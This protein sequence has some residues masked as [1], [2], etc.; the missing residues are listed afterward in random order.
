MRTP[1]LYAAILFVAMSTDQD[2][3]AF[4]GTSKPPPGRLGVSVRLELF[5]RTYPEFRTF[6]AQQGPL[7]YPGRVNLQGVIFFYGPTEYMKPLASA[8]RA[9]RDE[10]QALARLLG[11]RVTRLGG[12]QP[13]EVT[14]AMDTMKLTPAEGQDVPYEWGFDIPV[15]DRSVWPDGQYRFQ[16]G[17]S[18]RTGDREV[19]ISSKPSPFEI[20]TL[21]MNSSEEINFLTSL[22]FQQP[23]NVWIALIKKKPELAGNGIYQRIAKLDPFDVFPRQALAAAAAVD[24]RPDLV[25]EQHKRIQADFQAGRARRVESLVLERTPHRCSVRPGVK[26]EEFGDLI[27]QIVKSSERLQQDYGK[28]EQRVKATLRDGGESAIEEVLKSDEHW[29][30]IVAVRVAG[31]QEIRAAHGA[32]VKALADA[33]GLLQKEI[34]N[35]LARAYGSEKSIKA[36]MFRPAQQEVAKWWLDRPSPDMMPKGPKKKNDGG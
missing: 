6:G 8:L 17:P 30:P 1:I 24:L 20:R 25:L 32:M 18:Y 36:G 7:L 27:E 19:T 15:S 10:P 31:A 22:S 2:A 9:N 29:V 23:A 26:R 4:Q 34:V 21:H 12:D 16:V 3:C 13:V 33:R 11:L 14:E 5:F 35:S 28:L